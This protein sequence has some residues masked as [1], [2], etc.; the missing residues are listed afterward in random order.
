MTLDLVPQAPRRDR[1]GDEELSKSSLSGIR[2]TISTLP[3]TL[4]QLFTLP[5]LCLSSLDLETSCLSLGFEL[6]VR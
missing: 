2:Y 5:S 4:R 1:E 3:L 6:S